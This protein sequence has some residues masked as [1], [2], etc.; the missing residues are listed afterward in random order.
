M[1]SVSAIKKDTGDNTNYCYQTEKKNYAYARIANLV[2]LSA[3]DTY[4]TTYLMV[5]KGFVGGY[6]ATAV[7]HFLTGAISTATDQYLE[8][9]SVV[10][11]PG[12]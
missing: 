3:A 7:A 11:W 4:L 6:K 12:E 9:K 10:M 2:V 1:I 8:D 5:R